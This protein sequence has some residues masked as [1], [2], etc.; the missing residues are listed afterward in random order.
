MPIKQKTVESINEEFEQ[1]FSDFDPRA[2]FQVIKFFQSQ[3]QQLAE[4]AVNELRVDVD[5]LKPKFKVA[6]MLQ[7]TLCDKILQSFRDRGLTMHS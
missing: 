6:G 3:Y 5:N 1:E 7:N 4:E 2:S